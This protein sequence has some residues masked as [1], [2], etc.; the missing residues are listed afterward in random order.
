[1]TISA[2]VLEQLRQA[3]EWQEAHSIAEAVSLV[4][5]MPHV[6]HKAWGS[7][8]EFPITVVPTVLPGPC[9]GHRIQGKTI[10]ETD[11][12]IHR[13]K[14]TGTIRPTGYDGQWQE[15]SDLMAIVTEPANFF[16]LSRIIYR[17]IAL[18]LSTSRKF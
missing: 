8:L 17:A 18:S 13:I 16:S 7:P 11:K 4:K 5:S 6:S 9:Y 1:L 15:L 10:A 12:N 2:S 3:V 14:T